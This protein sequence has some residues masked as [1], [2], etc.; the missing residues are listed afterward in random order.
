MTSTV[1]SCVDDLPGLHRRV[2]FF[3]VAFAIGPRLAAGLVQP[4][5]RLHHVNGVDPCDV[6]PCGVVYML[7]CAFC[8][9]AIGPSPPWVGLRGGMAFGSLLVWVGSCCLFCVDHIDVL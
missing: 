9:A 3:L 7:G 4:P 6:D 2:R 8:S 1:L 5:D